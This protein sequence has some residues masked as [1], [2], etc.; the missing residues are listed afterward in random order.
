MR[1][2]QSITF[3]W[4]LYQFCGALIV[5]GTVL[6]IGY[7]KVRE[8]LYREVELTG[9]STVEL[10]RAFIFQNPDKFDS[11]TLVP[12]LMQYQANITDIYCIQIVD[13]SNRIIAD[14][15]PSSSQCLRDGADLQKVLENPD[16][17]S[18]GHIHTDH[19]GKQYIHILRPLIGIYQPAYQSNVI[20]AVSILLRLDRASRLTREAYQQI[21]FYSLVISAVILIIQ[22]FLIRITFVRPILEII[23]ATRKFG[24]R[25]FSVR[26]RVMTKDELGEVAR[27]FNYMADEVEQATQTLK[28]ANLKLNLFVKDLEQRNKESMLLA[29]M[30][31][32]L[33]T[34]TTSEESYEIIRNFGSQLFTGLMGTLYIYR[35]SRN[36]L[37]LIA[38]WGSFSDRP[39]A[40]SILPD[41]CWALRRGQIHLSG[42]S[43][44]TL[45]CKHLEGQG[46]EQNLCVP[47][48]AHG[49]ALGVLH[50]AW[51][52]PKFSV[53][54]VR[55]LATVV[56]EHFSLSLANLRLRE[57]LRNQSIRDVLTD[58]FNRRYFEEVFE[59]EVN[60]AERHRRHLSIIML[61]IDHFKKFNDV[62]GHQAGDT[63]LKELGALLKKRIR[64]GDTAC[65]YGGEEFILLMPEIPLD[66]TLHRAEEIRAA[67]ESLK[68][69]YR[70]HPL[71][72]VTI[73]MG[74]AAECVSVFLRRG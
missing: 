67:V 45:L 70:D 11:E 57:T 37:E 7:Y 66:T 48:I 5:L 51:A 54:E 42:G 71:G 27:A 14:T 65:R 62:Y 53:E 24:A 23:Q 72:T 49:E 1:L 6:W 4:L 58:L 36:D 41:D 16:L 46:S 20:G 52:N 18:I 50:L 40:S 73:S 34:A 68:V 61:D 30:G 17:N 26:A 56:A 22:V 60:R 8:D 10:L 3:K 15:T 44:G 2:R 63:V 31:N 74:V 35:A 43:T 64:G 12:L 55:R 39:P 47:M 69:K 25:Q 29:E 33:Q 38:V 21:L 32:L 59:Q 13:R 9:V 19:N 28:E